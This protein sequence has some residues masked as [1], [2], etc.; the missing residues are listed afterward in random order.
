MADAIPAYPFDR[1][2]ALEPPPQLAELREGCPVAHVRLPSGD[3]A[4]LVTR[5]D[6]ARAVMADP[7]FSR[8]LSREGAARLATTED[9]GLFS[10]GRSGGAAIRDGQGHLRWRRLLSGWFTQRKMEVWRP[11]V[12]AMAEELL[13]AMLA[14]GS[15]GNLTAG[16]ALPLPVRVICALVGAPAEDQ[17][18]FAHWSRVMLTLTGHTQQEVDQAYREFDAYVSDLVDRNRADPGDDLLSELTQITDAEDGRLGQ[19]ELI[20][21][22]RGLLL[23]GHETTSNM[24]AIMTAVLLSERS[25]YEAVVD[26]PDLVPGTVEEVLRL[27][28]T[29]SVIGGVPRYITEDIELSG[30]L[31]PAGSTV[32]PSTP[33]AN[34]DPGKFTDPDLFDPRRPNVAQHLTFGAGPHYCLGQ[35][36]ARVEL[37]VVLGLLTR[38]L[39]GLGLRDHPSDLRLR[40][41]GISGGLQEVWVTW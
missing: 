32:I 40:T 19:D 18:K 27:D 31:V 9:G 10:R 21:T 4:T 38:R 33:A 16:L 36:L 34:R 6:D 39:P 3:V 1:P 23:A 7:R 14:K 20:S 15:P 29:L 35:P 25:R 28:S 13:D 37:Q 22:V 12:Q 2:T 5:Y 24:I 17:D 26:D 41:G 11:R 30:T 8:D